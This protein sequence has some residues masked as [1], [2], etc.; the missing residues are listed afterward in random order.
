[1]YIQPDDHEL[2]YLSE[3]LDEFAVDHTLKP[4]DALRLVYDRYHV[5][6]RRFDEIASEFREEIELHG[7]RLAEFYYPMCIA[8]HAYLYKAILSNAGS[9]RKSTDRNFGIV[10]FAGWRQADTGAVF[11][12]QHPIKSKQNC[13]NALTCSIKMT[14]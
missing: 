12:G 3:L 11:E 2:E 5:F 1:M 7:A 8:I 14:L 13:G 6:E 4:V 9:F 10:E